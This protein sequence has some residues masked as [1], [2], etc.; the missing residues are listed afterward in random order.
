MMIV[1]TWSHMAPCGWM[2]REMRLLL[3]G[4]RATKAFS[5]VMGWFDVVDNSRSGRGEMKVVL[6]AKKCRLLGIPG[7]RSFM[8]GSII[9]VVTLVDGASSGDRAF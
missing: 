2:D 1:I 7:T 3:K 6:L 9:I 4:W 8:K 5:L